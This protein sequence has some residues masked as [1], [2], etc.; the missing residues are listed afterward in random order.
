MDCHVAAAIAKPEGLWQ[1]PRSRG[2]QTFLKR[3]PFPAYII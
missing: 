1:S 2:L 3:K